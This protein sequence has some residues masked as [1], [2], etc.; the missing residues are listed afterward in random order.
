MSHSS[1]SSWAWTKRR[2][3]V[4]KAKN[5]LKNLTPSEKAILRGYIFNHTKTQKLDMMDGV[6]NGLAHL[7]II[8]QASY[9]NNLLVGAAYN[10]Q[11]WAW[12]FLNE[13]KHLLEI[14][15]E[16]K[17]FVHG[18]SSRRSGRAR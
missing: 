9:I 14:T 1:I 15:E 5:H 11:P 12:N 13:N 2:F 6:V 8:Y 16:E 10:I 7:G 18:S 4:G 17:D 3:A